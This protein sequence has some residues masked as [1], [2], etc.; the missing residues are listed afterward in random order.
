MREST[1]QARPIAS[2]APNPVPITIQMAPIAGRTN[3]HRRCSGSAGC[4]TIGKIHIARKTLRPRRW[5]GA[6][7]CTGMAMPAAVLAIVMAPVRSKATGMSQADRRHHGYLDDGETKDV[8]HQPF[9]HGHGMPRAPLL[10]QFNRSGALPSTCP[11]APHSHREPWHRTGR[12]NAA[13]RKRRPY[14]C[15]LPRPLTCSAWQGPAPGHD[16]LHWCL[17]AH[18]QATRDDHGTQPAR[19][20]GRDG[21]DCSCHPFPG[22]LC[23]PGECAV[24]LRTRSAHRR[25]RQRLACRQNSGLKKW[26][27]EEKG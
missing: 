11:S 4:G 23:L 18:R 10:F 3:A 14:D 6:S 12:L 17:R 9:S 22:R 5:R 2:F 8:M 20:P 21:R 7:G 26:P 1:L 15:P 13:T 16:R 27:R 25:P 24:L 19:P